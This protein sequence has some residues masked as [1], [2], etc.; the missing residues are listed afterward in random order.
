MENLVQINSK[1]DDEAPPGDCPLISCAREPILLVLQ[2]SCDALPSH[3]DNETVSQA[4]LLKIVA[5]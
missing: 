1:C 2:H 4:L 3:I 5:T